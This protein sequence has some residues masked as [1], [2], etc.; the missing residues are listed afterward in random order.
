MST[1]REPAPGGGS[2]E[3]LTLALSP[4]LAPLRYVA[5]VGLG[6]LS[7][8]RQLESLVARA[9]A[10]A[11]PFGGSRLP[12][13]ESLAAAVQGF[14]RAPEPERRAA[15]ALLVSRLAALVALPPEVLA[16]AGR[17]SPPTPARKAAPGKSAPTASPTAPAPALP[18]AEPLA[19]PVTSLRGVGPALGELLGKK[20]LPTVGDVWSPSVV[21]LM[22][23]SAPWATWAES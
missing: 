22:R 8:L 21:V 13:V 18:P 11:V 10:A 15:L 9:V 16:L 19:A 2:A 4:L 23:N 7:S 3:A 5:R 20:G 12:A 17:A 6:K 14:D 1:P